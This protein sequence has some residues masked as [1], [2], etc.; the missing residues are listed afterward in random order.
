MENFRSIWS[1]WSMKRQVDQMMSHLSLFFHVLFP[2]R[3]KKGSPTVDTSGSQKDNAIQH[4]PDKLR[5]H[6]YF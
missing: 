2:R 6:S 1:P 5:N 4:F 3:V